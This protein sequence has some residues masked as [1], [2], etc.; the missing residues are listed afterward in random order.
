M[1][2]IVFLKGTKFKHKI[3]PI[4]MTIVNNKLIP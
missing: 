2:N 1:F 3:D 4:Q